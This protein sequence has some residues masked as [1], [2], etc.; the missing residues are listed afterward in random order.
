M[1]RLER[2]LLRLP[3]WLGDLLMARPAVQALAA[4][5]PGV[6]LRAITARGLVDL[7]RWEPALAAV[8]PWPADGA[9]RAAQARALRAWRP[10]VAVVFPP[11][12]SSAFWAW[13]AGAPVRL[14]YA[15]E[16]RAPLLTAAFVRGPRGDHHLADEYLELVE[17]LGAK[18]APA[19]PLDPPADVRA[20]AA[21]RLRALGVAGPWA[22][23]GPGALYGPAKRWPAE[24]FAAVGRALAARGITPLA[25]GSAAERDVCEAVAA[26]IGPEARALAGALDLL[27]QAAVCAGARVALCNDSGLAHLAAATGAPTV[28]VFGSTSSA[29]TAPLGPRV[30]VLQHAP[31]CSPCFQRTCVIGYRCL[32]AVGTDEAIAACLAAAA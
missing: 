18:S 14:G 13:R 32:D 19:M 31:F 28:A 30:R 29:W 15:H 16:G 4:A 23:L 12:F 17:P 2:I 9:G 26:A 25:C 6:A 22:V 10:Q 5:H 24:R 21:A 27:E 7:A 20:A 8:E 3:N 11:S 1:V